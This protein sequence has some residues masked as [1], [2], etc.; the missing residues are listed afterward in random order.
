[1]QI[2]HI[3]VLLAASVL[4]LGSC[5]DDFDATNTNPNRITTSSEKLD[6]TSMFEPILYGGANAQTYYSWFWCD[7]LIQ[8]TAFTGGTTRQEHR[9]FISDNDWKNV[10][11]T[12]SRYATNDMEMLKLATAQKN[13]AM[14]AVT[15]TL[16]VLFMQNLTDIYGDIPYSQAF[17][18]ENGVKQPVFDSQESVYQQMC[19]PGKGQRHL[20]SEAVRRPIEDFARRHVPFRHDQM[21]EIQQLALSQTALQNKRTAGYHDRRHAQRGAED[22]ADSD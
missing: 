16:K 8:H 15:L 13:E 4:T 2:N 19:R 20:C 11:N 10:W 9:Y 5:T 17:Q 21:A 3:A 7:E 22:A 14:Q 18:A 6:A 1:M 12:Y